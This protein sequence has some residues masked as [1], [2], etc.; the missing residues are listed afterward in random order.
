MHPAGKIINRQCYHFFST[1]H[2]HDMCISTLFHA[3]C[4]YRTYA[5]HTPRTPCCLATSSMLFRCDPMCHCPYQQMPRDL[6]SSRGTSQT[7]SPSSADRQCTPGHATPMAPGA[8]LRHAPRLVARAY[9]QVPRDLRNSQGT[10]QTLAPSPADQQCTPGYATPMT[11][12]A[13]LRH[14]PRLVAC[15]HG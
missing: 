12:G 9:Q 4:P 6:R 15:T 3:Q 14:A 11:P 1:H 13:L 5:L 10:S 2:P 8:H 7:L